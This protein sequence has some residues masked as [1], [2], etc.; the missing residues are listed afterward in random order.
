MET[1]QIL[2]EILAD[3]KAKYGKDWYAKKNLESVVN[4]I[5]IILK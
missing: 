3:R 5:K 2:R 1:K 4:Q